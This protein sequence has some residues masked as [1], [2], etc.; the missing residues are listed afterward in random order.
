VQAAAAREKGS[1]AV[2]AAE[3]AADEHSGAFTQRDKT[4]AD[5]AAEKEASAEEEKW[6]GSV[7]RCELAVLPLSSETLQCCSMSA[8]GSPIE[9]V[10][11]SPR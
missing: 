10:Q 2:E 9:R 1:K 4:A 6:Q 8:R 7:A 5:A 11:S 3:A